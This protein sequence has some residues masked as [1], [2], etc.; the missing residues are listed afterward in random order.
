MSKPMIQSAAI[1]TLCLAV[2]TS[3]S[4]AKKTN[5]HRWSQQSY[6]S[7]GS[8]NPY[9][10]AMAMT[11]AA[12]NLVGRYTS[13]DFYPNP[14]VLNITGM[15]ASGNLSGSMSGMLSK[16]QNAFD[17][18]YENWQKVFGRDARAVYQ[19]GKITITFN[20]GATYTLN[21]DANQLT[22][23]YAAEGENRQAMSFMKSQIP[24]TRAGY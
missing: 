22:G 16:P 19:N 8:T 9:P 4:L 10:N 24:I 1:A 12:Q 21:Q 7:Y 2:A 11:P 17:P 5:H 6:E 18:A 14:L 23:Q 13:Q 20:N 15:D 3:P